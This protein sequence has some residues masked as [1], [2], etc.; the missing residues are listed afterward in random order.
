MKVTVV[1]LIVLFTALPNLAIADGVD[2]NW[3]GAVSTGNGDLP[4]GF[5]FRADGTNLNGS[6]IAPDGSPSPITN[7]KVDG[8]NLTFS[9]DLNY[10]GNIFPLAYKGVVD[11]DQIKLS[12]E[13]QGQIIEFVVKKDQ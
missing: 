12:T 6:M 11:A 3:S 5:V 13:F 2:G 8:K 10:N 4:V 9:V 7:G 1:L